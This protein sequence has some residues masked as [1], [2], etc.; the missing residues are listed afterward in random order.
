MNLN[1]SKTE[2][3]ELIKEKAYLLGFTAI[4]MALAEP[5]DQKDLEAYKEWIEKGYHSQMG[6]LANNLEKRIDPTLLEDG[7]KTIISLAYNYYPSQFI[8]PDQY[9]LAWYSYAKDYHYIVKDK[10][11]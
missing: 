9:Q 2:L 8:A 3:T 10:L 5:I 11:T 7:T 4:G 6:Y 1:Y